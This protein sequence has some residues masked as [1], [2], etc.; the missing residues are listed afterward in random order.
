MY[1]GKIIDPKDGHLVYESRA[2]FGKCLS[3]LPGDA[4]VAFQKDWAEKKKH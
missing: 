2:F 1:P 3:R 4:Y